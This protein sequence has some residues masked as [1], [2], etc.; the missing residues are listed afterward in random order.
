MPRY[1][2]RVSE[3]P[4]TSRSTVRIWN[5]LSPT[6]RN[7]WTISQFK[8]KIR[9]ES[10]RSPVYYGERSRK[11]NILHTRW[12]LQRSSLKADINENSSERPLM[13]MWFWYWRCYSWLLRMPIILQPKNISNMNIQNNIETLL[14]GN[15]TYN[16]V[17]NSDFFWR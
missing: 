12:W 17:T 6:V 4:L 1:R 11:F 2:L 15:D 8:L 9:G 3:N 13:V 16:S 7:V 10:C 5:N 14:F